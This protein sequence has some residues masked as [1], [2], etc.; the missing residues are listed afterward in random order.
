MDEFGEVM[1]I[2]EEKNAEKMARENIPSI[3]W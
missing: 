3:L 2:Y 1:R